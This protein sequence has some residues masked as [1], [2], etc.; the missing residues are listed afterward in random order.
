MAAMHGLDLAALVG[1][2]PNGRVTKGDV[3]AALD[4]SA[5][6]PT[7][8]A[9]AAPEP[10]EPPR[11]AAPEPP[12]RARESARGSADIVEPTR[13]QALV[14][15]RMTESKATAPDF[16]LTVEI[17]MEPAAELRKTLR[18][19]AGDAPPPSFND[20]VLRACATALRAHPNVNAA[21]RDGHYERYSRVNVGVA[22]AGGGTLIVPTVFDTDKKSL[23]QI[24]R[25]SRDLA[26]RAR[27][28][29]LT[30]AELD[31]GTFSVSNLGMLGVDSFAAVL[32]PPQ[33]AILAV[34]AIRERVV[35]RDGRPV[36]R[37]TM[38]AALTC[39][40]RIVN[41]A[42][43]AAFLAAVSKTLENPGALLL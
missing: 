40:H 15:R 21:Y 6:V 10:A 19:L 9:P 36:V 20:M 27:D 23:G 3:R 35:A 39:D 41:G 11:A 33:A 42:E 12:P 32:N 1:N 38:H 26:A 29:A 28:G 13:I 37:R 24:A 14:A 2:G 16:T 7:L 31:G 22:V 34:G 8:P 18:A 25:E 5:P 17:D 4:H 43:G 30:P